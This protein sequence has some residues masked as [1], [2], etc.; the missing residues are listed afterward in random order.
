MVNHF[1]ENTFGV[2]L[3]LNLLLASIP[4]FLGV[5]SVKGWIMKEQ[6]EG[7]LGDVRGWKN[8]LKGRWVLG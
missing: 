4:A 7:G 6:T 5:G 8:G 1:V 2:I 3:I